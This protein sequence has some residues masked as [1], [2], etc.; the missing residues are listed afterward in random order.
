MTEQLNSNFS[1]LG[2]A[3]RWVRR[4]ATLK[5]VL[6]RYAFT[7]ALDQT[8]RW[9]LYYDGERVISVLAQG[10][11]AAVRWSHG[12]A[13]DPVELRKSDIVITRTKELL[14]R[15]KGAGHNTNLGVVLHLAD[16]LDIGI[17]KD[18]FQ[19]PELFEQASA[20]IRE[21]P[22]EVV[23]NVPTDPDHATQWRYYPLLS[24]HRA[25]V[26]RHQL[27]FFN[28]LEALTDLD[29]KIAVHSA[30]VEMLALYLKLYADAV[31]EKPHCFVFF[32][33]RF[34]VLVPAHQG[35]LDFKVLPHRQQN[36]PLAFG[37][38]LFSLLERF[39][40]VK[41]CVLFLVPCGTQEPTLLFRELEDFA[42]KNQKNAEGIEIEI[43]DSENLWKVLGE[44]GS[45]QI[46]SEIIQ[47]PEF[48]SECNKR[49][50]K[51][52]PH[53]LGTESTIKRF[54]TLSLETFWPD[55]QKSR[56][57]QVSRS[58]A[59]A[60]TLLR[61]TRLLGVLI[62]I[63]LAG[64]LALSVANASREP[65][66]HLLPEILSSKRADLGEL[67]DM[68]QYLEQWD[69]I[70]APRSQAW[71]TMDFVLGLLPE[72]NDVICAK[73]QYAIKQSEP[74]PVGP[75]SNAPGGFLR[76]WTIEGSCTDQGRVYL[77]RLQ[78]GSAIGKVFASSAVRLTVPN[79]APNSRVV[80]V[81]LREETNS[82]YTAA[83]K[84][85]ALPY[86]FRLIITQ[87]IPSNDPLAIPV[88]PKSK[89]G[90]TTS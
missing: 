90:K 32:Y 78:E 42:R 33:D 83:S 41:G 48:L 53:S 54:Q 86:Q 72:D 80:R 71:S 60:M 2:A 34:T 26:L 76:E 52:F 12:P 16:N 82:Q 85:N 44:S 25:V 81:V 30:P 59:V 13:M 51:E 7:G 64:W 10:T 19:N 37:D 9:H 84:A 21:I 18:E 27:E 39:G 1:D 23:V 67:Q 49:H 20:L 24:G 56:E 40:F 36:M 47:R 70:L 55:D 17:V 79:P 6:S 75:A 28:A 58:L 11:G 46:K 15:L 73:F 31:T 68:R 4:Q 5:K 89:S 87:T 38:D 50:G 22:A 8:V 35:I 3:H 61:A 14:Q 29:V 63:G 57:K 65:A 74:Q 66:L 62:L 88:L 69:K 77:E 45:D 43:P